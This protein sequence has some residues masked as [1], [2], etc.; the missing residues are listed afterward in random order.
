M[1]AEMQSGVVPYLETG[2]NGAVGYFAASTSDPEQLPPPLDRPKRESCRN[3]VGVSGRVR[4]A[5]CLEIALLQ[6]GPEG[7]V[8]R[9]PGSGSAIP[10]QAVDGPDGDVR[11]TPYRAQGFW[12]QQV[13]PTRVQELA[14]GGQLSKVSVSNVKSGEISPYRTY[15]ASTWVPGQIPPP[16]D[17]ASYEIGQSVHPVGTGPSGM[18]GRG[19]EALLCE[20]G[21]AAGA[22]ATVMLTRGA[23]VSDAVVHSSKGLRRTGYPAQFSADGR[24]A[25]N[26]GSGDELAERVGCLI[27]PQD[28]ANYHVIEGQS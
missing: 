9:W 16:L 23:G 7:A 4:T 5:P 21:Q 8:S 6:S 18:V 25:Q 3:A 19:R 1:I 10:G 20:S 15:S 14:F 11:V 12:R 13:C 17:S 26:H 27:R 2:R 22:V 28:A 24:E